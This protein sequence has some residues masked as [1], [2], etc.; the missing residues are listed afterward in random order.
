MKL[1]STAAGVVTMVLLASSAFA[2]VQLTIHDGR[3]SLKAK[4]ATVRQIMQEWARVGQTKIVNVERIPGGPIASLELNNV[5]EKEALDVLLRTV[6]GYIAAPRATTVA[7]NVSSFDRIVVMATTVAPRQA[8]ASA[9]PTPVFQTPQVQLPQPIVDDDPEDA[10]PRPPIF[11]AFPQ[12]QVVNPNQ[13][14]VQGQMPP[15]FNPP[16]GFVPPQTFGN[17]P[18]GV[19]QPPA[20]PNQ[21]TNTFGA[22]TGV[23]VPGMIVP[24]PQQPGAPQGIV[25]PGQQPNGRG[26]GGPR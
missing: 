11:G 22:P 15:G 2:D 5:T 3:V 9:P 23:A 21:P 20:Q 4:D 26:R 8:L 14:P 12:P 6:S 1:L 13:Q 10:P 19:G 18:Q 24:A 25:Q 16:P 7:A 17:N